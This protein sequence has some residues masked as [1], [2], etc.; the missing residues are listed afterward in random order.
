MSGAVRASGM[1]LAFACPGSTHAAAV[2]VDEESYP[3]RLGTA[4]HL[5]LRSLAETGSI[6]WDAIPE[7]AARYAVDA[8]E[9]RMLAGMATKLWPKLAPSFPNAL[10]ELPLSAE[11]FPGWTLSGH[12]DLLSMSGTVARAGDWKTGRIDSN[13]AQQMRAYAALLL[14]EDHELTEATATVI[15]IRDGEIESYTMDRAGLRAWLE[16]LVARVVGWDGVYHPG[17][18]CGYCQRS[19]ECEASTAYVRRDVA[20]ISDRA[21]VARA[22]GELSLMPPAE[23]IELHRKAEL[24]AGYAYRVKDAI[25]RHVLEHGAIEGEGVKLTIE[26]R[27]T[28]E[29]DP[30]AA[31]PVLEAA[32]FEDADFAE[33]MDLGISRVEKRIAQKAG[34][35]NGAAAVRE[36]AAKL[37]EADAV[38]TKETHYLKE[39]RT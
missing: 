25:K 7:V 5:V 37:G 3:G 26:S 29:L 17:R 14:L 31:F 2:P 6:Q 8:D 16:E 27:V 36:L 9:I 19:H 34:R 20:A 21:L 22:E 18:H 13:H 30:V 28:R 1:P 38:K 12:V 33:C 24:V 4:A 39:R 10:T 23:I 15:W 32:G 11:F 35:G